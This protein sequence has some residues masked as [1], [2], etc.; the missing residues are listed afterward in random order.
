MH[1]CSHECNAL[2]QSHHVALCAVAPVCAARWGEGNRGRPRA[3]TLKRASFGREATLATFAIS[4]VRRTYGSGTWLIIAARADVQRAPHGYS[5]CSIHRMQHARH[6]AEPTKDERNRSIPYRVGA[7]C[8]SRPRMAPAGLRRPTVT[9]QGDE[10]IRVLNGTP[11]TSWRAN[12]RHQPYSY[13][14]A[15]LAQVK[16]QPARSG[17][18]AIAT[19][20][21][22]TTP[23]SLE[24][25]HARG[26]ATV[27]A[28]RTLAR[29]QGDEQMHVRA[30]C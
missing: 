10:L 20:G 9:H 2:R 7:A 22:A 26:G 27:H 17:R 15:S 23:G 18:C 4:V 29:A 28:Q 30:H 16:D 11:A 6:S 21:R 19:Y 24:S 25:R 14:A 8:P 3:R 12:L 1:G 5:A 13:S